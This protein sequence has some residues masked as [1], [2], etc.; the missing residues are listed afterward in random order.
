MVSGFLGGDTKNIRV[1]IRDSCGDVE[2]CTSEGE[3]AI[4]EPNVCRLPCPR[5]EERKPNQNMCWFEQIGAKEH[6]E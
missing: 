2:I 4:T 6:E 1:G 5:A 3:R